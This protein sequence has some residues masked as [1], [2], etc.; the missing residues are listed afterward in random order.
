MARYLRLSDEHAAGAASAVWGS[1]RH[2]P[3]RRPV[4]RPFGCLADAGARTARP[5]GQVQARQ[6]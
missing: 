6:G 4:R 3:D 5:A 1:G 2:A